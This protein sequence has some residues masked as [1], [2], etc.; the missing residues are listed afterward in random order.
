MELDKTVLDSLYLRIKNGKMTVSQ[1]PQPYQE[2][3][4]ARLD[5]ES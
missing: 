3:L 2:E 4:Q 5:E 1:A